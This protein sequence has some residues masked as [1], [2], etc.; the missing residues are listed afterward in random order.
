LIVIVIMAA[1]LLT[2]LGRTSV[3]A[4]TD[5]VTDIDYSPDPV[6]AG[7]PV[8]VS[9]K[10]S[11]ETGVETVVLNMCSSLFCYPPNIMVKGTDDVWRATNTD[12]DQVDEYHFNITIHFSNGTRVWT[13]DILFDALSTDLE[14][15]VLE[16][17]PAK[18]KVGDEIDVYTTLTDDTDVS[19]VSLYY[20][21][22]DVCFAPVTMTKLANDT[23]HV[24]LGPFDNTDE[25]VKYNVTVTYGD[26]HKAWTVDVKFTPTKKSSNGNGD[27]DNGLI[28]ALG[29]VA[30]LAMLA[31]LAVTR[32][33]RK[34]G[35]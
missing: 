29:A 25:E 5:L 3:H 6:V 17:V 12:V 22:G 14:T 30:V 28:P 18:V 13:D 20:C 35:V 32:R 31:A 24:R 10:L 7:K 1:F 26:G 8:L 16:H 23:Y 15:D 21:Q 2:G 4:D 19:D 27:D 11:D 9:C 34:G 33:G